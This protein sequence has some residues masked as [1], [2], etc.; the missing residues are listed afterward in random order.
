VEPVA[1][2]RQQQRFASLDAL[3][4]QIARDAAE[5]DALLSA[6]GVGVAQAPADEG[7]DGP[8]QQNP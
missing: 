1:L 3:V 5:A 6:G 4:E 8:Q 2:L 7:S